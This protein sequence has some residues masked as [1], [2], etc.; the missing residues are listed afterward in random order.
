MLQD[1]ITFLGNNN[2][3]QSR[4]EVN[5]SSAAPCPIPTTSFKNN[6]SLYMA[7]KYRIF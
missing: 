6:K 2:T 5:G 3:P 7:V 4:K 1:T